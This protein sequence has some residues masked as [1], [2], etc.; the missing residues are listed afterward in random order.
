MFIQCF[1]VIQADVKPQADGCN[2][3]KYNLT[4]DIIESIFKTYPAGNACY[5]TTNLVIQFISLNY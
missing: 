5:I 2:G 3:L 1:F 4:S